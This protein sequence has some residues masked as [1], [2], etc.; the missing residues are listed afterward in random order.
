MQLALEAVEESLRRQ[1]AGEITLQSRRR[2]EFGERAYLN[3]MAAADRKSGYFGMKLYATGRGAPRFLVPLYS[4][5]TAELL[6]LIEAEVLGQMRTAAATGVATKYLAPSEA[7][8]AAIIGTGYQARTQLEAIAAVRRLQIVWA[9]GRD[10]ERRRT[11]CT[12]MSAKLSL[13][14]APAASA[15]EAVRDAE[16]IVTATSSVQPVLNGAWIAPGT[17]V[18]A[19]G[20]NFAQKRELDS[21]AVA[22]AGLIA[23]DSIAQCKIE[24]GDLIQAFAGDDSRWNSVVEVAE[25]VAGKQVGRSGA[26]QITLFKSTGLAAWDVAV[27][28]RVYERAVAEGRGAPIAL[29]SEPSGNAKRRRGVKRRGFHT[30]GASAR[31]RAARTALCAAARARRSAAAPARHC[32]RSRSS[33]A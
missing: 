7:R 31:G 4:A 21:A 13:P 6:A 12:E 14:V 2:L 29:W 15:E 30:R 23:V 27:A 16:I 8:T 26:E 20:S 5:A 9:Y 11:F 18:N 32:S 10:V 28:A 33:C 19:V 22:C 17:H 25:I 3:N 24:A 1:A